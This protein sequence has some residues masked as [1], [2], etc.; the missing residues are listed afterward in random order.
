M[1][2][3]KSIKRTTWRRVPDRL[4]LHLGIKGLNGLA[5][6]AHQE[7]FGLLGKHLIPLS[8]ENV[9]HGLRANDLGG[10]GN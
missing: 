4:F 8:H 9:Q 5:E 7:L 6:F 2:L 3:D 10:R 1:K